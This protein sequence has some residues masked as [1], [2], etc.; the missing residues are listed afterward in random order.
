MTNLKRRKKKE[1]VEKK[2]EQIVF[3]P[4][5]ESD[6]M[7]RMPLE[8]FEHFKDMEDQVLTLAKENLKVVVVCPGVLYG[9]GE[10]I[11]KSHFKAAWK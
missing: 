10:I 5:K 1:E 7:T 3:E 8:G 6:Y 2:E 11:F 9:A 4:Y